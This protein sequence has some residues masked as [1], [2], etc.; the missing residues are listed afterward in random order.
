MSANPV[1]FMIF[2]YTKM[3]LK[4]ELRSSKLGV[5][6]LLLQPILYLSIYYISFRYL[7]K[8]KDVTSIA[9]CLVG[10]ISYNWF[11]Q[12]IN[13]GTVSLI[14]SRGITNSTVVPSYIFII[15]SSLVCLWRYLFVLTVF[16]LFISFHDSSELLTL[17]LLYLFPVILFAFLVFTSVSFLLAS[18]YP[19]FPDIKH[20]VDSITKLF[21]FIS[22]IFYEVKAVP[23]DVQFYFLL[24]PLSFLISNLRAIFLGGEFQGFSFVLSSI[25]TFGLFSTLGIGLYKRNQ[26]KLNYINTI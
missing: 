19:I 24:N 17:N 23:E 21:L 9:S 14:G 15:S 16:L 2:I 6:W 5:L 12:T 7:L 25:L 26:S 18:V 1:L 4:V 10:L 13:E 20:I 11:S 3:K 8:S 22:C